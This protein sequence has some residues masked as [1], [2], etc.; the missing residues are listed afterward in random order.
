MEASLQHLDHHVTSLGF[1]E[2]VCD[3]KLKG[4]GRSTT[5]FIREAFVAVDSDV[6]NATQPSSA[7]GAGAEARNPPPLNGTGSGPHGGPQIGSDFVALSVDRSPMYANQ[8]SSL[9]PAIEVTEVG[10]MSVIL[11]RE[12]AGSI[13]SIILA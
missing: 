13:G 2:G 7:G 5:R 6:D 4:I 3:V 12:R 1:D 9:Q 10:E 11:G 8:L